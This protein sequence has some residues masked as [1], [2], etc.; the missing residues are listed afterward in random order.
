MKKCFTLAE[1]LITLGIIG[2]VAA[3]TIPTLAANIKGAQFRAKF[4]KSISTLN[5]AI[6]MNQ[7]QYDFNFADLTSACNSTKTDNPSTDKS[8]CAIFNGSVKGF[9][10]GNYS[11]GYA[12]EGCDEEDKDLKEYNFDAN[13]GNPGGGGPFFVP[14]DYDP[15]N[16]GVQFILPDGVMF[17][18]ADWDLECTKDKSFKCLG[19]I[20]VNGIEG[21]NKEIKCSDGTSNYAIDNPNYQDCTVSNKLINDIFPVYFYDET[22]IPATNAAAYALKTAK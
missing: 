20:D 15:E 17:M 13:T 6:R 12:C 9:S 4:K 22:V 18:I 2:I 7:A 11:V 16:G 21:P 19:L 8:I 1:V 14:T 10:M 5:Q 3:M